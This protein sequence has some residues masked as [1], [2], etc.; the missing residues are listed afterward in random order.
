M[1]CLLCSMKFQN[2]AIL[3]LGSNMGDRLATLQWCIDYIHRNI[4][5]VA[6]VSGVY[7]NPSVGFDGGDF[8]NCCIVVHT[9][10]TAGKLL[11]EL[12]QAELE[13]GRTRSATE[14]H[15]SR[16]I[17]I[18][19]IA[20]NDSVIDEERLHIP[21]PRMQHRNFVLVP[22]RDVA[23]HWVHPILQKDTNT[24][25]AD[26]GDDSKC[27]FV[28]QLP[29]PLAVYNLQRHG[30]IAIEGNIGAGKTSLASKVAEDFNGQLVLERFAENPFLPKFY[31]DSQ[32]YAFPLEMSFLADRYQQLTDDLEG[33]AGSELIV[34]DYH[35]AKS[36]IFSKVTL[37]EEEFA[38]YKKV[39][40]IMYNEMRHPGLYVYLHQDTE[41]LLD[42]IKTRGRSYEQG[43]TPGYLDELR[44][45][46]LEH[47]SS[48]PNVLVLDVTG[49]DFVNSQQ[50]YLWVLEQ[51]H[52]G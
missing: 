2:T 37:G 50:D 22:M 45:G 31:E 14:R 24:L 34:A 35:I 29:A 40:D 39:F 48:L 32:R 51:V 13:G 26:A 43:I 10:K 16:T 9:Q 1:F 8:Y 42:N 49:R 25:L 52:N 36:L 19:M 7:E 41:R 28:L 23:P 27:E 18:D 3:S 4:A 46:Y 44:E 20:F 30:Y 21:H 5:T 6:K 38:L 17:D 33:M 47:I 15:T 12:L 11:G